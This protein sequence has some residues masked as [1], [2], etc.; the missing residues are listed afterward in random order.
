MSW[1]ALTDEAIA[2]LR[3]HG[4]VRLPDPPGGARTCADALAAL[5]DRFS[6]MVTLS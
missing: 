3:A 2:R 4:P 1:A 6:G 5:V